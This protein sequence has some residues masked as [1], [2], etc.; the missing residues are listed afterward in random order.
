MV[1]LAFAQAGLGARVQEPVT[2]DRRRGGLRRRLHEAARARSSGPQHEEPLLARARLR[3]VVF[4]VV[5]WAIDSSPGHV[6]QAIRENELRVEVLGLRAV[7]LQADVVR[8]RVVPRD[9]GRRRL[10][11]ADQRRDAE[12]TT[13]N[14]TLALLVMVVIGGTG[15][16]WGAMIGGVLYTY[17]DHRLPTSRSSTRCASLPIGAA[18][19]A[20]RAAV[21]ARGALHPRRLLRSRA[22]SPASG[23]AVAGAACGCS[24]RASDARRRPGRHEARE[25]ATSRSRTRPGDGPPVLLMHGLGYTRRG[26][27]A[28]CASCSRERF[29]VRLLRQPRHRRERRARRGRTRRASWPSDAVAGARRGR[30]VERA[31]VVGASLGGMAAQEL[32]V[33]APGARRPARARVHD[34]GRR[35]RVPDARRRRC[36]LFAEAPTLA[37]EVALR[38]FVENALA[39]GRAGR[40]R[41]GDLCLPARAPA[42]PGRLAGAGRRR[43][44]PT[45]AATALERDRGADARRHGHRGRRRRH[46]QRPAARRA[47]PGARVE[48]D[49]RR[50]ATCSSGSSPRRSRRSSKEFLA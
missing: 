48:L 9:A 3:R 21:R 19:A 40:A 39:P 11:A 27:G 15:T 35:G 5:R 46:A 29:R 7:R 41:R 47:I 31:H 18:D 6:W 45:T 37:P 10:P 38:R 16:R 13:P 28:R 14:F 17:L 4:L 26:L 49:R 1:T 44:R 33:D 12:V 30:R 34:A 8:A 43:G 22:G 25:T 2:A 50:A 20:V 32:A 36:A 23:D 24:S 42:R